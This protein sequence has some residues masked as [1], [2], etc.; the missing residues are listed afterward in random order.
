MKRIFNTTGTCIPGRHFMADISGKIDRV[1][2]LLEK[3]SN[4]SSNLEVSGGQGKEIYAAW[5]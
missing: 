1:I 5:V 4:M 3:N 2:S